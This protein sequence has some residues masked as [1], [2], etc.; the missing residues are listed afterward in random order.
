MDRQ[1]QQQNQTT[2]PLIAYER[3]CAS[4]EKSNKR[5]WV[6]IALLTFLLFATN[7]AWLL[8]EQ[9]FETVETTTWT[10]EQEADNGSNQ[11][12]GG[13]YYGENEAETFSDSIEVTPTEEEN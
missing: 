7:V 5:Q 8:Y 10:F 9:Q 13:D 12:I 3:M 6:C 1:N 4:F 2:I 11:I